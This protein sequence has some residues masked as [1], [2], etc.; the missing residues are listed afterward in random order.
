MYLVVI[1]V[2]ILSEL[3]A[4]MTNFFEQPAPVIRS[5]AVSAVP[6]AVPASPTTPTAPVVSPDQPQPYQAPVY[7]PAMDNHLIAPAAEEQLGLFG[8][9]V[10]KVENLLLANGARRHSYAFGK[11]SRLILSVYM[12]TVYFDRNRR[13]GAFS[14]EPRPPY[15]T[16][17]PDARKFFFDMFLKGVDLSRFQ[18]NLANTK[19]EVRYA[20]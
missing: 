11:Y 18:A 3:C 4:Q 17:E 7:D 15:K 13:V 12:V 6:Q 8:Q 2:M 16:V 10:S 19:L 20:P 5:P 14:V 9:P 1:F